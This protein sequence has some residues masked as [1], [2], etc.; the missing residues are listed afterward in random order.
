MACV[1]PEGTQRVV[2]RVCSLAGFEGALASAK[3]A[4]TARAQTRRT[5]SILAFLPLVAR[6]SP[7]T[8]PPS[9]IQLLTSSIAP[10]FPT[11]LLHCFRVAPTSG[12]A[13]LPL[14]CSL[15]LCLLVRRPASPAVS[16][17]QQTTPSHPS[18]PPSQQRAN[19]SAQ[20]PARHEPR[21]P[22][23]RHGRPPR[24]PQSAS[25]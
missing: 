15:A 19:P 21:L 25:E 5:H 20:P 16:G 17:F 4:A 12:P 14:A 7:T 10:S 18:R 13:L 6:V 22:S 23:P 1:Q 11:P 3:K 24:R 8:S 9:P 2:R